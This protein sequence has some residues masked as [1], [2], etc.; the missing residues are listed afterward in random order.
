MRASLTSDHPSYGSHV[1]RRHHRRLYGQR[2]PA[3]CIACPCHAEHGLR[4]LIPRLF[5]PWHRICDDGVHRTRRRIIKSDERSARGPDASSEARPRLIRLC[6][7]RRLALDCSSR[8]AL[9]SAMVSLVASAEGVGFQEG[10]ACDSVADMKMWE[11]MGGGRN[12]GRTFEPSTLASHF[13]FSGNNIAL[14]VHRMLTSTLG[15]P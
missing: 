12:L 2:T 3:G 4:R 15:D 8:S 5:R 1:P 11:M 6:V 9:P 7:G 13:D 10:R 14:N